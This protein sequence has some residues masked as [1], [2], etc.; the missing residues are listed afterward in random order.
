[1]SELGF[2][3]WASVTPAAGWVIDAGL[4][5]GGAGSDLFGYH[6]GNGTL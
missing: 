6:P 2:S 4:F 5:T 3:Q 1:M